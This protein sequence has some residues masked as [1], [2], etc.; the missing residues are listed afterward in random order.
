MNANNIYVGNRYTPLF[1]GPWDDGTAYE[2]LSAVTYTDGNAYVSK[3]PVPAGTLPT[4]P[5]YWVLWGSGN[6]A[7]DSVTQRLNTV[8][9]DVE[10]LENSLSTTQKNLPWKV[11]TTLKGDG[12][13]DNTLLFGA[14][15]PNTP[16]ALTPGT[17]LITGN[18]TIPC[19]IQFIPG[20]VI[21]YNA[22]TVGTNYATVTFAKGFYVPENTQI[23]D[24]YIVPKIGSNGA[25]ITPR[26]SWYGGKESNSASVNDNLFA[27]LT[28]NLYSGNTN[29]LAP[30]ADIIIEPGQYKFS[31][32]E[33][34]SVFS[35]NHRPVHMKGY[36]VTI[37]TNS[38]QERV[39]LPYGIIEGFVL[40]TINGAVNG[41]ALVKNCIF[42]SHAVGNNIYTTDFENIDFSNGVNMAPFAGCTFKRCTF[43]N[44]V[45]MSGE[46]NEFI[47]CTFKADSYF[48]GS[49]VM[50][51]GNYSAVRFTRCTFDFSGAD[52][53]KIAQALV[54]TTTPQYSSICFDS[55]YSGSSKIIMPDYASVIN[56]LFPYASTLTGKINA[57]NNVLN[58][59][60]QDDYNGFGNM[61][62]GQPDTAGE[63]YVI[64]YT[65]TSAKTDNTLQKG[66]NSNMDFELVELYS[67]GTYKNMGSLPAGVLH[68][69]GAH[70]TATYNN[71][72]S[73]T[74]VLQSD[75]TAT[76]V[77]I[78]YHSTG[79]NEGTKGA[80]AFLSM[81][82]DQA[83]G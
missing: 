9:N 14:L 18:V 32:L 38:S 60:P 27:W 5:D 45:S 25:S 64:G 2:S 10:N 3:G 41:R 35:R 12:V 76:S 36:G 67:D 56:C 59:R 13:T 16:I 31:N 37:N 30:Y 47:D 69:I 55:C 11:S 33:N 1:C 42:A 40:N 79:K 73:G 66:A 75:E 28:S 48:N 68:I 20:A 54:F 57:V 61:I 82:V 77:L 65:L 7:L 83:V 51:T 58:S 53:G 29:G 17:Y 71:A 22:A 21:K 23:F 46:A 15:D 39:T 70:K 34:E 80:Y 4:D 43:L 8:E 44:S 50:L 62:G 24:T 52:T 74:I 26:F 19:A 63:K 49:V 81:I 78:V 6:A 72:G